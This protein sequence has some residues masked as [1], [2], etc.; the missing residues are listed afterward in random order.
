M[1]PGSNTL[2]ALFSRTSRAEPSGRRSGPAAFRAGQTALR[3]AVSPELML[4]RSSGDYPAQLRLR[5]VRSSSSRSRES[6]GGEWA[7]PARLTH[8]ARYLMR[9]V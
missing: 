6:A 7:V 5:P 9:I 1:A 3:I 8:S 4:V 2:L